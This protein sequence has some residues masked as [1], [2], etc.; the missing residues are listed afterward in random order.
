MAVTNKDID[1]FKSAQRKKMGIDKLLLRDYFAAKCMAAVIGTLNGP[2]TAE[3]HPGDFERYA[4]CAYN[5]ADA[6]LKA[7]E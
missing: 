7:R 1:D 6:M 5:M 3:Q 2:V 4:E